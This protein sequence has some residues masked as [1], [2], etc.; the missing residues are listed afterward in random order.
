MLIVF[1]ADL[2]ENESV[3]AARAQLTKELRSRAAR[4]S[5]FRWPENR[6][7]NAKGI[8][9]LLAALGPEPVLALIEEAL[10][11][12]AG[13]RDLLPFFHSNFYV[14]SM[15]KIPASALLFSRRGE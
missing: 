12:P 6:P 13:P 3:Q 8:D 11:R 9:D 15:V 4:V 1:D 5:W 7:A 10:Q 14:N 2:A